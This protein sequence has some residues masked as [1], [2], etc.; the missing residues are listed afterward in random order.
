MDANQNLYQ[1]TLR[2]ADNCLIL[3][4][5]L[6]EWCGHGPILEQDIALTNISLDLMGQARNYFQYAAKV[7]G[8]DKTED[9]IA[10]LRD[11]MEFQN[12]LLLEQPNGDFG[13][14]VVRQFFFDSFHH[15]FLTKMVASKD[16]QLSAIAEKSIKEVTYH[17]K[18]SSQWM[19]RLGDGTE[20]SHERMQVAVDNL[21][22]YAFEGLEMDQL[23]QVMLEAEIGPDL[24]SIKA[25][26]VD[27]VKNILN[28]ATLTI[29]QESFVQT[30][31]K[32]GR[33][34]EYLGF[35]LAEMQ[36]MQ[37]AFPGAKW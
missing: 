3:G 10:F 26:V 36:H 31:G 27:N 23:D 4:Q 28:E 13:Q 7:V 19:L 32:D 6:A 22:M 24:N 16:L 5:R 29:P 1:Y 21:W 25:E 34:T 18:W 15:V 11:G 35:I 33:H 37:R 20:E 30:G 8:E 14:T 17:L 2:M 9:D 12:L